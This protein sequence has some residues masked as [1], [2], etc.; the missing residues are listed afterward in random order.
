ME[1][2]HHGNAI[3]SVP[4]SSN[5]WI[6]IFAGCGPVMGRILSCLDEIDLLQL[7]RSNEGITEDMTVLQWAYLESLDR[8]KVVNQRWRHQPANDGNNG[9]SHLSRLRGVDFASNFLYAQKRASEAFQYFDLDRDNVSPEDIPVRCHAVSV[10]SNKQENREYFHYQKQSMPP[11]WEKWFD[12]HSLTTEGNELLVLDVFLDISFHRGDP[13]DIL[14]WRGFRKARYQKYQGISVKLDL[15]SLVQETGWME[16][17][18]FRNQSKDY[19]FTQFEKIQLEKQTKCLMQKIQITMHLAAENYHQ[20]PSEN[21]PL[22][23]IATGGFASPAWAQRGNH[24]V[25]ARSSNICRFHCRN[26]RVPLSEK[27]ED[28]SR[29]AFLRIPT[30]NSLDQSLGIMLKIYD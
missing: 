27:F 3:N 6:D 24:T 1:T 14:S 17:L 7:E 16:L 28:A 5:S 13:R 2:I 19:V 11:C 21:D 10:E 8:S 20:P 23:I 12:F 22:L 18:E 9:D 25:F 15:E 29:S 30:T 4:R 26:G